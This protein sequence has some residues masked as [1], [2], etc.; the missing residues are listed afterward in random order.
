VVSEGIEA[1]VLRINLTDDGW[2][3]TPDTPG[4]ESRLLRR[5][6]QTSRLR[7]HGR[8]GYDDLAHDVHAIL[9]ADALR[10]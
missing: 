7:V 9:L 3:A 2:F 10:G 8:D 6:D 1:P 4:A 5:P